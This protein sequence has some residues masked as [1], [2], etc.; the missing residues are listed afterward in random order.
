MKKYNLILMFGMVLLILSLSSVDSFMPRYTHKLI[1]DTAIQTT[2]NTD[3]ETFQAC[4]KYPELCYSGNVLSDISVIFY[5]TGQGLYTTTHNPP[6]CRALLDNAPKVPGRDTDRMR[7]CA[8]GGCMHQPAD[9]V[10]HSKMGEMQGMVAHAI[11]KSFLANSVIHVFAEQKLDNY[12]ERQYPELGEESNDYL[13]YYKEC[14][15]LFVITMLGESSYQEAGFNQAKLNDIFDTFITEVRNSQT[16]YDKSFKSKSIFVTLK[17]IPTVLIAIYLSIMLFFFI[18]PC[19]LVFRVIRKR[20]TL[21]HY[22]GLIIFLPIFLIMAYFLY[23]SFQGSAFNNFINFIKP[24]SELVPIGDPETWINLGIQNTRNFL[25]QGPSWLDNT[26]ASGM[27]S[28]PVLD[29]ATQKILIYDYL[30]LTAIVVFFIV[31]T[32]YLLRGNKIKS[33]DFTL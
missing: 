12:V 15:D 33:N 28:I 20:A 10:S 18:V 7:A 24:I 3:S 32:I 16:G 31:F 17:S 22:I 1:H 9:I 23:S 30:I 21:R 29:E 8:I 26:D 13:E 14:Q 6:F 25:N 19:I 27:G 2:S 11:E 5:Y 4:V